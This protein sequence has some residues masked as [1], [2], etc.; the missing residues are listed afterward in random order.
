MPQVYFSPIQVESIPLL[1]VKSLFAF[2]RVNDVAPGSVAS[3]TFE[4][5]VQQLLLVNEEGERVSA[6]GVYK[7]LIETGGSA[8]PISL[9]LQL[10]GDTVVVEQFPSVQS[11]Q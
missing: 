7:V 11:V 9:D 6:P 5:N 3:V 4:F 1:P 10:V 8:A 2:Q